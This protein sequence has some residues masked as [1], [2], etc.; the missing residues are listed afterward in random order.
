MGKNKNKIHKKEEEYTDERVEMIIKDAMI[1]C[2][3]GKGQDSHNPM[4]LLTT[5]IQGRLKGNAEVIKVVQELLIQKRK[6]RAV[7]QEIMSTEYNKRILYGH[8][9]YLVEFCF[10][11][12]GIHTKNVKLM[13]DNIDE[14]ARCVC[15][16]KIR[17]VYTIFHNDTNACVKYIGCVCIMNCLPE[18]IRNI[19]KQTMS[20]AIQKYNIKHNINAKYCE[21]CNVLMKQGTYCKTCKMIKKQK[22]NPIKTSYVVQ[23]PIVKL[24][25]IR[26][27]VPYHKNEDLKEKLRI[28]NEKTLHKFSEYINLKKINSDH[29]LEDYL[30]AHVT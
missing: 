19:L 10:D 23:C 15:N 6:I 28:F 2:N 30:K 3:R 7:I 22:K 24:K 12:D 8:N 4:K 18:K 27:I 16:V 13:S 25:T 11:E 21:T 9:E 20:K 5:I 29:Y 26:E 17:N 1:V 14:N